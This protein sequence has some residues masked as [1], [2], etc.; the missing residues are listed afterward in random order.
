M[1][2]RIVTKEL[3]GVED[4][5]F[6]VSTSTQARQSGDVP[7]TQI[8]ASHIPLIDIAGL[9]TA[10]NVE[11]ALA[12]LAPLVAQ[13]TA[14]IAGVL[15]LAGEL[16]GSFEVEDAVDPT[17]PFNWEVALFPLGVV[18]LE[19]SDVIH[20]TRAVRC[21]TIGT[22]GGTLTSSF[23]AI[24]DAETLSFRVY[25]RSSAVAV[26][27]VISVDWYDQDQALLSS[28]T[29]Y[30]TMVNPTNWTP[31][32]FNSSAPASA[33]FYRLRLVGGDPGSVVVGFTLFD[34]LEILPS[35]ASTV[36]ALAG[37]DTSKVI[38]ANA[39]QGIAASIASVLAGVD[40][41]RFVTPLSL[42]GSRATQA[43]VDAGVVNTHFVT[44]LTL[45]TT[46]GPLITQARLDTGTVTLAGVLPAAGIYVDIFLSPY[47]F[48]P[49]IHAGTEVTS[50]TGLTAD[51]ADPDAPG[52]SL[53]T[54]FL[55]S[56]YDV[57][58]RFIVL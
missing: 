53:R 30:D 40:N 34:G 11:A 51:G 3:G 52:F 28:D 56:T 46:P 15:S 37:T 24:A 26:R 41:S 23:G 55:V 58:Y 42:R 21:E 27:N 5:L 29:V 54:N 4:L 2:E 45:E 6:G 1:A 50:M 25:I 9:L 13:N 10:D 32:I 39:L 19:E 16:N 8:N 31:F 49:M 22:G 7:I 18:L 38:T 35:L 14:A 57:D 20:G 43:Q 33:G 48:F 17:R 12:E 44:P 47:S 36:E